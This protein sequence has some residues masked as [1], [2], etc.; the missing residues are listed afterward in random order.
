MSLRV[1]KLD[2]FRLCRI[3]IQTDIHTFENR[4]TVSLDMK[5]TAR[6][7]RAEQISHTLDIGSM[8]VSL[9][10]MQGTN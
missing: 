2:F 4:D 6:N 10:Y 9:I 7:I 1:L 3:T 5:Q 8:S